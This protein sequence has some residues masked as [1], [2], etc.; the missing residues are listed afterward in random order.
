MRSV[1]TG[2]RDVGGLR[3]RFKA[4]AATH[5]TCGP[6]CKNTVA[7]PADTRR[8]KKSALD[9][10][11]VPRI[12]RIFMAD[13]VF[14]VD[15]DAYRDRGSYRIVWSESI[16]RRPVVSDVVCRNGRH[17]RQRRVDGEPSS[18]SK[19]GLMSRFN[20]EMSIIPR[21][22]WRTAVVLCVILPLA[23]CALV[24]LTR[25]RGGET[26]FLPPVLFVGAFICVA[27]F[28]YILILGYIAAD[29]KRRGMRPVLWVL[30]ALFIPN[31]IGI[32][33]Y[34]ILR[35]PLLTTCAACGTSTS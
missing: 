7:H 9:V 4:A 10:R 29:A 6:H 2:I 24:F 13:H 35:E 33:L 32:I 23:I 30:L 14:D 31:A 28:V 5:S 25:L 16:G 12:D 18:R 1:P 27:L 17:G 8:G 15:A 19:E 22:A 26:G 11:D 20:D 3:T 34:F 21:A